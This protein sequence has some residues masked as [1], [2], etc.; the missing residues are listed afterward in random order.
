[1]L[2][3]SAS[4]LGLLGGMAGD[5]KKGFSEWRERLRAGDDKTGVE[6]VPEMEGVVGESAGTGDGMA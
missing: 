1:M 2:V 3:K 4:S 5:G 6:A